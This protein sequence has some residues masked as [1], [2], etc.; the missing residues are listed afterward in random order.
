MNNGKLDILNA[1]LFKRNHVDI[2]CCSVEFHKFAHNGK[3]F[4]LKANDNQLAGLD[5]AIFGFQNMSLAN[6]VNKKAAAR[7][8]DEACALFQF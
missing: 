3:V 2:S 6:K 5:M 8:A 7:T 1:V 4:I